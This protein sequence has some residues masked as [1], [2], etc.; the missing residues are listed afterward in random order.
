MSLTATDSRPERPTTLARPAAPR[1][2]AFWLLAF[3]F[4]A[5]AA[6]AEAALALFLAGTVVAGVAVGAVFLGSLATAHRLAP[7]G[8]R[9]Q[10]ISAYF[11]GCYCGLTIPVVGVGIAAGFVGYL[12]AVVA[13]SVLLA[14]LCIVAL[15]GIAR[16]LTPRPAEV[17]R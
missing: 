2:V 10:A 3:V 16:A 12:P 17:G 15:P 4:A 6:L 14:A 1:Q 7:A 13:L 5:T 11:V 9:A 8:R